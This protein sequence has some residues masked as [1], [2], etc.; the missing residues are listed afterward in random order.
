MKS[1]A[2]KLT[3][4]LQLQWVHWGNKDLVIENK[5]SFVKQGRW[6]KGDGIL[7]FPCEQL[8]R[9]LLRNVFIN[10]CSCHVQDATIFSTSK[11]TTSLHGE[12]GS[13]LRGYC[14]YMY[15]C[16]HNSNLPINMF[17][18]TL[19]FNPKRTEQNPSNKK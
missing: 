7:V 5:D 8:L 10:K 14:C 15:V 2:W 9:F 11:A 4:D 12:E 16:I 13:P 17:C 1:F 19:H 6:S 18:T 3:I